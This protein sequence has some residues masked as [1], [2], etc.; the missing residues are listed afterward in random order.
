MPRDQITRAERKLHRHEAQRDRTTKEIES[1]RTRATERSQKEK[2]QRQRKWSREW[3]QSPGATT[4]GQ[5]VMVTVLG[6]PKPV[7]RI[8]LL[9]SL[10]QPVMTQMV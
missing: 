3:A 5:L 2:V 4:I 8:A 7:V 1:T 10:L 9:E 6:R